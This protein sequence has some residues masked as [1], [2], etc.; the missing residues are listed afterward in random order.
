[1]L[2]YVSYDFTILYE[3]WGCCKVYSIGFSMV[4]KH[5]KIIAQSVGESEKIYQTFSLIDEK[6]FTE[7]EIET[8]S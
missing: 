4:I 3:L 1:M 7:F 8:H 2:N 5:N 6:V